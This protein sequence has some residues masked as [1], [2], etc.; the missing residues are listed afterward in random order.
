MADLAIG[1]QIPSA[2]D[3]YYQNYRQW[4]ERLRIAPAAYD[5]WLRCERLGDRAGL[6]KSTGSGM[7]AFTS[8]SQSR[9]RVAALA[10]AE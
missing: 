3:S 5:S 4:C 9:Q 2:L 8:Y 10:V 6:S 7:M 1:Q